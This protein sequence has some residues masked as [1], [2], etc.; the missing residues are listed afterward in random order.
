MASLPDSLRL[1]AQVFDHLMDSPAAA[2]DAEKLRHF[3]DL[4]AVRCAL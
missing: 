2:Q 3:L 4:V 1:T